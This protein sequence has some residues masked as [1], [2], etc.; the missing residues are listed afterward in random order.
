MALCTPE[1]SRR[2]PEVSSTLKETDDDV[3]FATDM[4]EPVY[5]GSEEHNYQQELHQHGITVIYFGFLKIVT[6][7]TTVGWI[8]VLNSFWTLF[9][10]LSSCG[11][12]LS[13]NSWKKWVL[14]TILTTA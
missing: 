8:M 10:T 11:E 12:A 6:K 14:L 5:E 1:V 13:Y 9:L 2:M 3:K 7:E 4:E